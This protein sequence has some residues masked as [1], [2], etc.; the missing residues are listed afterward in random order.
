[1]SRWD[2]GVGSLDFSRKSWPFYCAVECKF[3]FVRSSSWFKT[4]NFYFVLLIIKVAPF[5]FYFGCK[6][7]CLHNVLPSLILNLLVIRESGLQ[8]VYTIALLS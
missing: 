6:F 8:K 2:V 4:V 5:F 7:D 1:M 3:D